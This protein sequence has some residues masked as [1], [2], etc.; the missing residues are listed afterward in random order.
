MYFSDGNS[1]CAIFC[2][3]NLFLTVSLFFLFVN[4]IAF[5]SP[6]IHGQLLFSLLQMY[7]KWSFYIQGCWPESLSLLSNLVLFPSL[8]KL[9]EFEK[10]ICINQT[11]G[12]TVASFTHN[13]QKILLIPKCGPMHEN[14]IETLQRWLRDKK[15]A[16]FSTPIYCCP[17]QIS[18]SPFLKKLSISEM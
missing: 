1:I 5:G 2:V 8:G 6:G 3:E 14:L 15:E 7:C 16:S 9:T 11:R 18:C 10:T 17:T 4:L 13:C 12:A